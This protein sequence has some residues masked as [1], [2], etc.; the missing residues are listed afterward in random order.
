MYVQVFKMVSIRISC[1]AIKDAYEGLTREYLG[2]CWNI[3]I[4][5]SKDKQNH[6][7]REEKIQKEI[8][9]INKLRNCSN[10]EDWA[11]AVR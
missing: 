10:C 1:K 2:Q 4:S 6:S 3:Q 7:K 5:V 9:L 8:W 11:R